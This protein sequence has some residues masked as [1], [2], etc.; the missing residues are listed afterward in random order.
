MIY[1]IDKKDKN[2]FE[3]NKEVRELY[4]K[5]WIIDNDII[6]ESNSLCRLYG[7]KTV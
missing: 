4:R 7:Q 6:E 3:K 1:D 5:L 2:F